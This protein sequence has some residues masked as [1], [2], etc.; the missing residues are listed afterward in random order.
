MASNGAFATAVMLLIMVSTAPFIEGRASV[1]MG[2]IGGNG[3]DRAVA[4]NGGDVGVGGAANNSGDLVAYG[5]PPGPSAN[6][7]VNMNCKLTCALGGCE[8]KCSVYN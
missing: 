8:F 5:A 3:N 7:T 2:S 4:V 6:F 1:N